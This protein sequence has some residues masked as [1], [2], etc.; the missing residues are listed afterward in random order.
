MVKKV[1]MGK[2][3]EMVKITPRPGKIIVVLDLSNS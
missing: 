1:F 3:L 2:V